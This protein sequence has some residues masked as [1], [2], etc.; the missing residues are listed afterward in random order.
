MALRDRG[1]QARSGRRDTEQTIAFALGARCGLRSAEILD[2]APQ[3]VVETDASWVVCV[4]EGKGNK[5]RETPGPSDLA[6]RIRFNGGEHYSR[7]IDRFR[8]IDRD[9]RHN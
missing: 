2:V 3:D 6:M 8:T 4:W 7:S 9:K 5:F 1:R